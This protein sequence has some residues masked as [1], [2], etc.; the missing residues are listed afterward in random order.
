MLIKDKDMTSYQLFLKQDR[1]L[2][3]QS[4]YFFDQWIWNFFFLF[5]KMGR[6]GD[7]KRNILL[8][9]PKW[10]QYFLWPAKLVSWKS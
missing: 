5:E 1:V 3:K 6:S 4:T 10:N 9:W 8:G 7:G 2:V